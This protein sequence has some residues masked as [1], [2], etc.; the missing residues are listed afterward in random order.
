[1]EE[2]RY[3][4]VVPVYKNAETIPNLVNV[5]NDINNKLNGK[6]EAVFVVDGSPDDSL[7][8]LHE[9]L[10]ETSINTQ[11]LVHSRNFG[12]FAAIRTGLN[13][14]KGQKFAVMAA[15]LQEP[16]E[17]VLSIFDALDHNGCDVAIGVRRSRSDSFF[18][19]LTSGI[20]WRIYRRFIIREIPSGGVDVFGCNEVFR[21][22]LLELKESR[23]SLISLIFWLGFRRKLVYYDRLPRTEGRSSWTF[24]KKIDYMLDSIFAF[25]DLPIK[26]LLTLGTLG[27][28][29]SFLLAVIVLIGRIAGWITIPGYTAT[30]L[31]LLFFGSVN[32]L[33][34][35]V[36]GAYAWRAYENSK[37]RPLAVVAQRYN[38]TNISHSS[39]Q[40]KE[41]RNL[42]STEDEK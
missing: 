42:K 1:M 2:I 21:N 16:P 39:N 27:I 7:S 13:A 20:F 29:L 40:E 17:L 38:F 28:T 32:I 8:L 18:S 37:N 4:I 23:S 24:K 5:L 22:Q 10:N 41:H 3:S 35:G 14:A 36:V 30:M 6:L 9:A 31:I 12:S 34:F 19:N 11:L 33:G 15:D 25:T 26:V